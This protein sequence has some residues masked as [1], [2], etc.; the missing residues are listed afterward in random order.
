MKLGKFSIP[1]FQ[2]RK[3]STKLFLLFLLCQGALC[4]QAKLDS[5]YNLWQDQNN[6]DSTRA[7][8]LEEYI[9]EESFNSQPDSA[10][11]LANRLYEF[12]K[13]KGYDEGTVDALILRGYVFFRMGNYPNAFSS[14]EEGLIV[15]EK[16]NYKLGTADI[17][18]LIH[19]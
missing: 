7:I 1:L 19:I 14:Y 11:V 4:A 9:Y 5:L 10:L 3:N 6:P 13:E 18:S 8:A 2:H 15:S 17:L 12:T 16:I